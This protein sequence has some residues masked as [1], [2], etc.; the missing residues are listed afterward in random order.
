MIVAIELRNCSSCSHWRSEHLLL[1]KDGYAEAM[2]DQP[3]N[4]RDK[5]LKRGS[6]YCQHW[7]KPLHLT[8]A[9][10]QPGW[11]RHR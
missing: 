11:W 5:T 3:D 4:A 2:C 1:H 8:S 7:H 9:P 6:D 10:R